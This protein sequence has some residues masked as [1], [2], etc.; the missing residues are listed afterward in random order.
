MDWTDEDVTQVE[1]FN[2]LP[3]GFTSP[4]KSP[5]K[6]SERF[7]DWA[8]RGLL[9][10]GRENSRKTEVDMPALALEVK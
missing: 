8:V 6:W 5:G 2:Y 7:P 1:Q 9:R 3:G 4:V 10:I